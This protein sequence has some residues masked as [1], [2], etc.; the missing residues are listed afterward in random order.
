MEWKSVQTG[1]EVRIYYTGKGDRVQEG[2]AD[3]RIKFCNSVY[4]LHMAIFPDDEVSI[5]GRS[6]IKM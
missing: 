3:R 6:V 5:I 1:K 2:T 4:Y